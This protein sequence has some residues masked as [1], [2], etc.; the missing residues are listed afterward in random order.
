MSPSLEALPWRPACP[1]DG[2]GRRG[3]L[4][5]LWP[6]WAVR[7]QIPSRAPLNRLFCSVQAE[8]G[9]VDMAG[10]VEATCGVG[11]RWRGASCPPSAP[12]DLWIPT[13]IVAAN[14]TAAAAHEQVSGSA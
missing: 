3:G 8:R 4:K 14:L 7:V 6:V 11:C 10:L 13:L 2:I 9:G 5:P 12:H 1:G